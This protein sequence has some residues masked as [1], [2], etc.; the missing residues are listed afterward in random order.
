MV[1][2][3]GIDLIITATWVGGLTV[4]LLVR[5]LVSWRRFRHNSNFAVQA[6]RLSEATDRAALPTASDRA[7]GDVV[8][9]RGRP[10]AAAG[11]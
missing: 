5:A 3:A 10:R 11:S 6:R 2:T 4:F 9:L 8:P 7:S 1:A